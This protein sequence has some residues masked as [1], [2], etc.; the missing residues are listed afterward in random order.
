MSERIHTVTMPKWGM[1]MTEGKVAGWLKAEGDRV[2]AGEEFVEVETEKITNVVEA[3]AGGLLRRILVQPGQTAP[4]GTPIAL[5]AE[6][7]APAINERSPAPVT[8]IARGPSA[9]SSNRACPISSTTVWSSAFS[10]FCLS[11]VRIA[12]SSS[13]ST[14]TYSKAPP[15]LAIQPVSISACQLIGFRTCLPRPVKPHDEHTFWLTG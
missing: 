14:L 4:V 13:R 15:L 1:T 3:Q 10:L 9:S 11:I 5:M 12:M 2:E 6:M 8:M 7:S